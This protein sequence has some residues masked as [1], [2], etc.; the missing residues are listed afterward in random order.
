M[1]QPVNRY[2]YTITNRLGV[3]LNGALGESDFT[4]EWTREDEGRL[5]YKNELPS[6]IVFT[7]QAYGN[8]LKLEQSIY[9][10]DFV[11]ITVDRRCFAGGAGYWTP[12]F[13]G[14]MSLND[15]TW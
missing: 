12:W 11:T 5:D 14:R 9:R 13:S 1:R 7:G 10:C 4:I 15:G 8:L 6:K 2:Q 3:L